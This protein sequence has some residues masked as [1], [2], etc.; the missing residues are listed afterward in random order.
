MEK[1]EFNTIESGEL[2]QVYSNECASLGHLLTQLDLF[3]EKARLFQEDKY[4]LVEAIN[5]SKKK[6]NLLAK[7]V[8]LR[9]KV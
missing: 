6:C 2:M 7:E 3:E 8:N 5:N 4:K 1:L 9:S